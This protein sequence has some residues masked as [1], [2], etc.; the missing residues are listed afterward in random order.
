MHNKS[1]QFLKVGEKSFPTHLIEI[2]KPIVSLAPFFL[3]NNS[4]QF[5]SSALPALAHCHFQILVPNQ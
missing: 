5:A 1:I 3:L 2:N 4:I